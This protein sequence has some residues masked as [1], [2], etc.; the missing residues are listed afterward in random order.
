MLNYSV[1]K[2]CK[3]NGMVTLANLYAI[4]EGKLNIEVILCFLLAMNLNFFLA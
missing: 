4:A 1:L 2:S 3:L